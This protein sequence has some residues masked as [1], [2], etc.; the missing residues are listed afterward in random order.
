M[1]RAYRKLAECSISF[2]DSSKGFDVVQ[3]VCR[4]LGWMLDLQIRS[5]PEYKRQHLP[6]LEQ[7]GEHDLGLVVVELS[8]EA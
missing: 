7:D 6:L 3:T 1:S 5:V 8:T 2:L 4:V